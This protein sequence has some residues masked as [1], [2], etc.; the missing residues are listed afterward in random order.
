MSSAGGSSASSAEIH[1]LLIEDNEAD[2]HIIEHTLKRGGL[3]AS[4]RR[5]DRRADIEL[6]LEGPVDVAL[7]DYSVPGIDPG[8]M[9]ALIR[10]RRPDVPVIVV[11]GTIGEELAVEAMRAG[12]EDYLLKDRLER[13]TLAVRQALERRQLERDRHRAEETA[14]LLLRSVQATR[15]GVG[16]LDA[17]QQRRPLL[18]VNP[19]FTS[20][21]ALRADELLGLSLID[22]LGG[23]SEVRNRL[24]PI[25]D[26][27]A[28]DEC[29]VQARRRD[30]SLYWCCV[31]IERIR[32]ERQRTTHIA[33]ILSDVTERRRLEDQNRRMQK[34]EALGQLAGG[35]AHD[36]NNLLFVINAYSDQLVREPGLSPEAHEAALAIQECGETGTALTRQLLHFSRNGSVV[37]TRIDVNRAIRDLERMLRPILPEPIVVVTKLEPAIGAVRLGSGML[38]RIV[39]NLVMNAC[40]ALP[41]GG[42]LTIMTNRAE[43][44][45]IVTR[46]RTT[47]PPGRYVTVSVADTGRGMS[48]AV[49]DRLFE[50]FF[51]TKGPERGTGLGLATVYGMVH[52]AGGYIE[53]ETAT[54]RGS[55]FTAYLPEI[56]TTA[57]D[58]ITIEDALPGGSERVLLVEDDAR[59]RNVVSD[60]LV[61][62]GYDVTEAKD[63]ET[64]LAIALDPSR[65]QWDL[66]LTDA[67]MPGLGGR[68]LAYSLQ[69]HHPDLAVIFMSGYPAENP[70]RGDR[71]DRRGI[72]YLQKPFS[73]QVLAERIRAVFNRRHAN[74]G[75]GS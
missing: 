10:G 29:E 73:M 1:V 26:S 51:T 60:M 63:G 27:D 46:S 8:E 2:A 42:T 55:E 49:Q 9:I 66:L 75:D 64:A 14:R 15:Q 32:D 33:A 72:G 21:V 69:R 56:A 16:L 3:I 58:G 71:P 59:I 65:G 57:V 24:G 53:V 13:L 68:Q 61:S 67:V 45:E 31:V 25:L 17:H 22:V 4:I 37:P 6:A 74:A 40:D 70:A 12:A 43:F 44:M 7:C 52:Q 41:H 20:I 19:A 28:D 35:V 48:A 47:I 50:P 11:S 18:F 5:V 54:G 23:G 62:L 30:G 38:E 39:T 34:M 36:F